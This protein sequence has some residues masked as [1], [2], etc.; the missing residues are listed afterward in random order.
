MVPPGDYQEML[1]MWKPVR[2]QGVGAASSTIDANAQPAG[3]MD[4]WRRQLNCLF[5]LALNGVPDG[6]NATNTPY[7]LRSHRDLHLRIDQWRS[8]ERLSAASTTIRRL[9]GTA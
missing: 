7:V 2:L 9:T 1:L 3:K 4:P 8:V 5:G 6:S